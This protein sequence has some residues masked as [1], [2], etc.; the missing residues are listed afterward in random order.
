VRTYLVDLL[1]RMG[2][3]T[4]SISSD[5]SISWAAHREAERLT[6]ITMVD[7]LA[8]AVSGGLPT[9]KRRDC[10][11]TIGKI[12]A[13][14]GDEHCAAV[15]LSLLPG[16]T[17]KYNLDAMLHGIG[18]IPK[19]PNFDL[20]PIFPLLADSRWM[21]RHAAINALDNSANPDTET[22]VLDHLAATTDSYEQTYCHAVL[23]NIGT[24]RSLPAVEANLKSRKR[25]VK[26]SA[27]W[28]ANAIRVRNGL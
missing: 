21:V 22:R 7:E 8:E 12:G 20:S 5:D 3:K 16:E 11:F 23:S 19:G 2:D 24:L 6:D 26:E 17:N 28:A 4:K 14:L 25:D 10:Y 9:D 1:E 18:H 27:R 15:L 13:N